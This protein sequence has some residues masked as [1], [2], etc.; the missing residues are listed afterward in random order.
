MGREELGAFL[1]HRREQLQPSDVGLIGGARRRTAG[2]R[3]DEV[4]LLADMSTDYYERIEQSRGP[5]PSPAMLGAI[6][7][8]LRLTLDERDHIYLLAGQPPPARHESLG[9]ADPGLM[10]VLNAVAPSIPALIS[11]D[12]HDVVAQN[13]LNVALL[14]PIAGAQGLG[15]NFLWRWFT[16]EQL[17]SRYLPDQ[18]EALGREY[19]ADLRATAG[20]R[21]QDPTVRA[22]VEALSEASAEFRATWARQEVA[23]RRSTRKVLMN[24]EVGRLDLLCDTVLSPPSGQRIV[25]FRPQPGTGTG[26]RLDMLRVLGAQSFTRASHPAR[27]G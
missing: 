18:H 10:C 3:R 24:P 4:A 9:Y 17:R 1:R 26:E 5:R 19:V 14:G 8:A 13:P 2:L 20:Q 23:V 25:L 6:A 11:D 21:N 16:D 27:S 22:L 12:L 7:R 15:S